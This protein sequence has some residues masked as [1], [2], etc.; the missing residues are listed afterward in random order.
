MTQL[1]VIVPT[2]CEADNLAVLVPRIV[3]SV[4]AADIDTEILIV[5]DNSPDNTVSVCAELAGHF[6]VRLIV[7]HSERGLSSAVVRGMDEAKGDVLLVMDADLSHP[8]ERIE[9]LFRSIEEDDA[10]FVIGSRYVDGGTTAE[11]WGLLRWLNSKAATILARPLTAAQDP[12]AGF[13]A[14]RREAFT[15]NRDRLDPIG[16]KIGLE[17]IVKCDCQSV[18]EVPIDFSDRLNG[19]SKLTLTEQLNYV[20]HLKRLYEYRF[21]ESAY[22]LK[23]L[24]VGSTGM[25]VDLAAFSLLLITLPIPFARAV[26]IWIAMTWNF[27]LNR[28]VTFNDCTSRPWPAQYAGFCCSCLLGAVVNWSASLVLAGSLIGVSGGPLLAAIAGVVAGTAFNYVLC[29]QFVFSAPDVRQSRPGWQRRL[30]RLLSLFIPNA[31]AAAPQPESA[32]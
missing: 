15:R 27:V 17:L 30:G 26:A 29:R 32:D 5:D 2:Y 3:E 14:L 22:L 13:F 31:P 12:M 21:R 20:R 7:R 19:E 18:A 28:R 4:N 6:P 1:T 9:A 16:Y 23:F 8:P 10:D 24:G 25:L 11:D